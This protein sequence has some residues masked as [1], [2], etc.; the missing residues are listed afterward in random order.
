MAVL[1]TSFTKQNLAE[2]STT[3]NVTKYMYINVTYVRTYIRIYLHTYIPTYRHTYI[4]TD[5]QTDRQID[6]DRQTDRHTDIHTYIQHTY[7]HRY[8]HT[9]VHTYIHCIPPSLTNSHKTSFLC[10][11]WP[12]GSTSKLKKIRIQFF[13]FFWTVSI[14]VC[15][16]WVALVKCEF[17]RCNLLPKKKH[18]TL[19]NTSPLVSWHINMGLW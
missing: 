8:I 19:H 2:V 15:D 11:G 9:H 14:C 17:Y 5:R 13:I 10:N 12:Q 1:G 16:I 6:R 7:I 18:Y 3:C 4:H